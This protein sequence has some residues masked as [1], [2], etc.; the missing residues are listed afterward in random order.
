M[1][2]VTSKLNL[3]NA[4]CK[5]ERNEQNEPSNNAINDP[6]NLNPKKMDISASD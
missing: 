4:N 6:T 2:Y 3:G 1:F 5:N